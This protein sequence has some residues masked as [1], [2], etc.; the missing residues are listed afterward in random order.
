MRPANLNALKMFDAAARHLNFRLAAQE[1]NLTQ[2]AV[3]QQVRGLEAALQVS[4]FVRRARG[5]ELTDSGRE[6]Q[7][8]IGRALAII[9]SATAKLQLQN[10]QIILSVP[11][12]FASKWLVPHLAKFTTEHPEIDLQTIASEQLSDFKTD[13][14][15]IAIR[16][17]TAP[18]ASDLD[19]KLLAPLNLCA[20][21]STEFAAKI[22]AIS[23]LDDFLNQPLIQDNHFHWE[24]L[25]EAVNDTHTAK[26][27]QFNQTALAI[28]AA[29]NGQ[30]IALSPLFLVAP[31]IASGKLVDLWQ[32]PSQSTAKAY[33]LVS[34]KS[35]TQ[36]PAKDKVI[37]WLLNEASSYSGQED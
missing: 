1:L 14:V 27:L 28:D 33:Y 17:A 18:F 3:A 6:Y 36:N 4:L 22:P 10:S 13:A 9:D 19:V 15:D 35:A 8:Q 16:I 21:C 11:P 29:A 25:L 20:V 5:L 31:E 24:Y 34:Q 30:G 32:P 26:I 2:G 23:C 12:S 37:Q 7:R